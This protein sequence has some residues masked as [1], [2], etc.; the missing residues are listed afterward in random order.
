MEAKS[1]LEEHMRYS[2]ARYCYR[3]GKKDSSKNW[4]KIFKSF[5]GVS[6]DDYIKYAIKRN[7]KEQYSELDCKYTENSNE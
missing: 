7:L 1:S 6:L 2:F 3:Q 4:S 5:W